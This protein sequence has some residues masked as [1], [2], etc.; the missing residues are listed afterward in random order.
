M[1]MRKRR[2]M[3]WKRREKNT[4]IVRFLVN[5]QFTAGIP[6]KQT[7][8]TY[9]GLVVRDWKE[10]YTRVNSRNTILPP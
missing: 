9:Q 8:S 4:A 3:S 5:K 2:D 6:M 10:I 1:C 7:K